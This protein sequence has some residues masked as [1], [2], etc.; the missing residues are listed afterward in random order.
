MAERVDSL[1]MDAVSA[2]DA[3]GVIGVDGE[4]GGGVGGVSAAGGE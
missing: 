4:I 1:P 3:G 2:G